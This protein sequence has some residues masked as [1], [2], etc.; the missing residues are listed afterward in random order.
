MYICIYVYIYIY[1]YTYSYTNNVPPCTWTPLIA[2][3]FQP[4]TAVGTESETVSMRKAWGRWVCAL[5]MCVSL[6][7]SNMYVGTYTYIYIYTYIHTYL[8][9]C[10]YQCIWECVRVLW[11]AWE[12]CGYVLWLYACVCM[13]SYIIYMHA[14]VCVC[15]YVW[16]SLFRLRLWWDVYLMSSVT[17]Q[18]HVRNDL[19]YVLKMC[20][21]VCVCMAPLLSWTHKYILCAHTWLC[22]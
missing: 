7:M 4:D 22:R 12:A 11:L 21:Y 20:R 16:N 6:R 19:W 14:D 18:K 13:H 9:V 8:C 10:V 17:V 3:T 1:I 15:M 2:H 5:C